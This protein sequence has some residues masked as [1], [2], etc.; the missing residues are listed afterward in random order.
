MTRLI[1]VGV[2]LTGLRRSVNSLPTPW[3][4]YWGD[5]GDPFETVLFDGSFLRL[6]RVRASAFYGLSTNPGSEMTERAVFGLEPI[7]VPYD[8][9]RDF[10]SY[11]NVLFWP[12]IGLNQPPPSYEGQVIHLDAPEGIYPAVRE[13][14]HL[15]STLLHYGA[16]I[17]CSDQ[18]F[19]TNYTRV[20][21]TE[22]GPSF[23]IDQYVSPW[24]PTVSWASLAANVKSVQSPMGNIPSGF[25]QEVLHLGTHGW[26]H[27]SSWTEP[28]FKVRINDRGFTASYTIWSRSAGYY[29]VRVERRVRVTLDS[30]ST[31]DPANGFYWYGFNL[32]CTLSAQYDDIVTCYN[33]AS[34]VDNWVPVVGYERIPSSTRITV[35]DARCFAVS[36]AYDDYDL[37]RD[38]LTRFLK[39]E[40]KYARSLGP[41]IRSASAISSA[42]ALAN[43][44]DDS[45]Y[46]EALAE[47]GGSLELLEGPLK[48][49]GGVFGILT[50]ARSGLSSVAGD[51]GRI[52]WALANSLADL[53]LMYSFGFKPTSQDLH[54]IDI[55]SV[56][57]MHLSAVLSRGWF[58]RGDFSF[59][60]TDGNRDL[61][62]TVR[63]KLAFPAIPS[64]EVLR[65]MRADSQGTLPTFSRIWQSQP[66]TFLIDYGLSIGDRMRVV[67]A[68]VVISLLRM[69]Y[70]VHSYLVDF[71]SLDTSFVGN[72]GDPVKLRV[73]FRETSSY[74]SDPSRNTRFNFM[75]PR[76]PSIGV[77]I[78]LLFKAIAALLGFLW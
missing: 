66:Y 37:S 59:D 38:V 9:E 26:G 55:L 18:T 14:Y 46:I 27:P 61:S 17:R 44:Q 12:L 34:G 56:R 20:F 13:L 4:A 8:R 11:A 58:T 54:N 64:A 41:D 72:S 39:T 50:K 15:S 36:T 48:S 49:I 63:S 22:N 51:I 69:R 32:R 2:S 57:L 33:N 67:E 45:N 35:T 73:Y 40:L 77:F 16:T 47:V 62:I 68:F 74:A 71:N 75:P 76:R 65:M 5:L 24:H 1:D 28:G 21:Y 42:D 7:E 25:R 10:H 31:Y 29:L 53:Q 3:G 60:T 6:D 78:A 30:V 52:V 19:G 23:G 43:M 70:G